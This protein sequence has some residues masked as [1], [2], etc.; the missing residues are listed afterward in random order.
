[1][2]RMWQGVQPVIKPHHPHAEA[3]G[4]QALFLH[5]LREG[6]PAKG[7][8]PQAPGEPA[9]RIPGVVALARGPSWGHRRARFLQ[10]PLRRRCQQQQLMRSAFKMLTLASGTQLL[11]NMGS[12]L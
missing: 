11:L 8:P 2:R 7:G 12:E 6:L 5:A 9:P 10:V 4:L 1:M 3:Y